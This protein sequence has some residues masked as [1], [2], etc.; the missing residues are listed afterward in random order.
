MPTDRRQTCKKKDCH[1][2]FTRPQGSNRIYCFDCSPER[3]NTSNLRYL[4]KNVPNPPENGESAEEMGPLTRKSLLQLE[5]WGVEDTWQ[6]EAALT[7][8]RQIDAGK[9]GGSA[10][11]AGAI[12]AHYEAMG[13]AEAISTVE[14][15]DVVDMIFQ[16]EA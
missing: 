15:A 4:P 5:N 13:R 3:K 10:G 11:V 2:Q 16:D 9:G 8:A 14:E 7:L 1:N 12:K 6:A